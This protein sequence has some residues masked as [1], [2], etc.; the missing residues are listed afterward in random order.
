LVDDDARSESVV[1]LIAWLRQRFVETYLF[2]ATS[3]LNVPTVYC[4]LTSE[5]DDRCS[6][7][8]GAAAG[9]RMCD[10]AEKAVLEAVSIMRIV[11][12][13]RKAVAGPEDIG[14]VLDGA[15]YMG[16]R[17]RS[18]AFDFLTEGAEKRRRRCREP[19]PESAT[20]A[21]KTVVDRLHRLGYRAVRVDRTVKELREA[22]LTAVNMV[23]PDLQPMS[24][25]PFAQ[26]KAHP[27]L[28]EA[29]ARMGYG[30]HGEEELNPW[31]QPFA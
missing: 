24:L 22:G 29:P 7:V 19:L 31:P 25:D 3:D 2:D 17:T 26:F 14:D 30:A 12:E 15:S 21:L 5:Y 1:G 13:R 20:A 8:V 4:L 10:A 18:G 11:R 9:R 27:R 23:V 28:Y 16:E 6:Q